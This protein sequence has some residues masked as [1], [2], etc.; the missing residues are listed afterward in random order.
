M[1]ASTAITRKFREKLEYKTAQ[2]TVTYDNHH[3]S[4]TVTSS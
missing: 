4:L 2:A 3:L 1:V